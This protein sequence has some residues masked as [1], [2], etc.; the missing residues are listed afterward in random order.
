MKKVFTSVCLAIMALLIMTPAMAQERQLTDQ[1]KAIIAKELVPAMLDQLK[2]ISG[3]NHLSLQSGLSIENVI[4]SPLF[5]PAVLT[6]ADQKTILFKPDSMKLNLSKANIPGIPPAASMFLTD[7]KLTFSNYKGYSVQNGTVDLQ[8]PEKIV[9]SALGL[10][11]LS[12]TITT[13]AK[14][15]FLPF[16][17]LTVDLSIGALLENMMGKGGK[18]ITFTEKEVSKG[19]YDYTFVP[20]QGLKDLL[21]KFGSDAEMLNMLIK[22]NMAELETKGIIDASLYNLPSGTVQIPMGDATMYVNKT[23]QV[24]SILVTSYDYATGTAVKSYRKLASIMEQKTAKDLVITIQDSI[25]TSPTDAWAWQETQVVTMTNQKAVTTPTSVSETISEVLASLL[26]GENIN[27]IMTVDTIGGTSTATPFTTFK[28]TV[29]SEMGGNTADPAV[30]AN[31]S[32]STLNDA[33]VL[34]ESMKIK[35]TLPTKSET[36]KVEF[37]P[38][39][40]GEATLMA[41]AYIKSNLMTGGLPDSNE[42]IENELKIALTE[43]GIRVYNIEN[44]TYSIVSIKGAIVAKGRID[45][46]SSFIPTDNIAKGGIYV[47]VVNEKGTQ[48]T[49]KFI[50]K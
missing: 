14:T 20:E 9:A 40:N 3:I 41:T 1:E 5:T 49:V 19:A 18:L 36:I 48:Q 4:S 42:T 2:E 37:S 15:G 44:G 33:N 25:R 47:L 16:N 22:T 12:M 7:I 13:G 23:M 38:I 21:T 6:R 29:T 32:M 46:A 26:S 30:I 31:I 45:S 8:I 50:N 28:T 24:D 11:L 35:I 27:L 17:S 43:G 34:A 10:D 39:V